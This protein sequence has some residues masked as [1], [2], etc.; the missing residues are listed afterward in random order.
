M[1]SKEF[2]FELKK[3]KVE[4]PPMP[5]NPGWERLNY[6]K[7][8]AA[9]FGKRMAG[10]YQ[11][12]VPR[13]NPNAA[14]N[15]DRRLKNLAT[16]YAY[17]DAGD[18]KPNYANWEDKKIN[19]G[20]PT[21]LPGKVDIRSGDN[22]PHARLWTST[23]KQLEDK[24][25]TSS[26]VELISANYQK[27]MSN[28]GTLYQVKP[29]ALILELNY[30]RDAEDIMNAFVDLEKIKHPEHGM[31]SK[32]S[33]WYSTFPWDEINKHF[34]AIHHYGYAGMGQEFLRGWE[35][36]STAWL[37]PNYLQ[38]INEVSVGIDVDSES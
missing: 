32:Y 15:R 38:R 22:K 5:Y 30:D 35:C 21:L 6:L 34:D 18:L 25:W 19:E 3:K 4:E 16:P 23:A 13:E 17:T 29:G 28:T 7:E 33:G 12:F 1:R 26:W 8:R 31:M 11:L 27:W 20:S 2:L 24:S 37:N 36:E 14:T 10:S 9:E